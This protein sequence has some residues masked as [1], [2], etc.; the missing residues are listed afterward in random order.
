MK[1]LRNHPDPVQR[2]SRL[3]LARMFG[4]SPLFVGMAAPRKKE[5]VRA[6]HKKLEEQKAAWGERK[7]AFREARQKRKTE[8]AQDVE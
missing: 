3:E 2:K 8:W 1:T 5:E 4:C 6:I 7:K